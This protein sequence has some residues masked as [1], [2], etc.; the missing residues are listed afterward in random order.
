MFTSVFDL[1]NPQPISTLRLGAMI[2]KLEAAILARVDGGSF[3]NFL[4]V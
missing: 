2:C 4:D 1:N 3:W